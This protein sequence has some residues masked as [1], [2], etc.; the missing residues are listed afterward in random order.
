M[1]LLPTNYTLAAQTSLANAAHEAATLR[2]AQLEPE[3]VLLGLLS[4]DSGVV[5]SWF[6]GM[7]RDPATLRTAI[8]TALAGASQADSSVG[9]AAPSYRTRR[10]LTEAADEARR[11]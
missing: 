5:W 3:H 1:D 9:D 4:P 7:M 2:A 8:A 10:V 11:L 6:T